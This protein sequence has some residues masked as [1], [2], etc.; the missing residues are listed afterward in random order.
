MCL[1]NYTQ[2]IK[3]FNKR[4]N[5]KSYNQNRDGLY[6]DHHIDILFRFEGY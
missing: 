2:R 4:K 6:F 5:E 3:K 1:K